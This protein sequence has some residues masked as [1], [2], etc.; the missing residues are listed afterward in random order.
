MNLLK[1]GQ[2]E[3][4]DSEANA[5]GSEEA[6]PFKATNVPSSTVWSKPASATGGLLVVNASLVEGIM[7]PPN[8]ST[9]V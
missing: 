7:I 3:M 9:A 2:N 6:I 8:G 5:S 1:R 4:Y